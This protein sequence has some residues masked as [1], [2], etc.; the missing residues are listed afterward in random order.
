MLLSE[1]PS[2]VSRKHAILACYEGRI[3]SPAKSPERRYLD[4]M[5]SLTQEPLCPPEVAKGNKQG[6]LHRQPLNDNPEHP[7]EL[8][9]TR[10][11][12]EEVMMFEVKL[13]GATIATLHLDFVGGSLLYFRHFDIYHRL[14][15][16]EFRGPQNATGERLSQILLKAAEDFVGHVA[17]HT[18][19]TKVMGLTTSQ[20]EVMCWMLD[21][22]YE[23][24]PSDRKDW[25]AIEAGDPHLFIE[26]GWVHRVRDVAHIHQR[27]PLRVTHTPVQ[28]EFQKAIRS[29]LSATGVVERTRHAVARS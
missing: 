2:S 11:S 12:V 17:A 29:A 16:P 26:N 10:I 13:E 21:Q 20:L 5:P 4:L 9:I 7:I 15:Q 19:H 24:V 23:V 25:A 22:G 14:V 1:N 28:I 3:F 27:D 18:K 8:T 6:V